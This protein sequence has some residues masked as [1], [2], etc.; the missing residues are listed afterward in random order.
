M[1]FLVIGL[2]SMGKRRIR[3]LQKNLKTIDVFGV[4]TNVERA[5][6]V[7]NEFGITI[8]ESITDAIDTVKFDAAL[9]CT[10]PITHENIILECLKYNLNVFTEINLINSY[11]NRVIQE[12]G[13]KNLKIYLSSTFLKRKEIQFIRQECADQPITYRYHA[14]QYLPDWH[15]WESYKDYFVSNKLTNACRE[16]LAIELPWLISCFGKVEDIKVFKTKISSLE[17]DYDD[18]YQLLMQHCSGVIGSLTVNVVS[19]VAKRDFEVVGEQCQLSWDGTPN[20]LYVFEQD[21]K[22]MTQVKLYDSHEH[23]ESYTKSIVED[24]YLEELKEFV[25]YLTQSDFVP[26]Y[27]FE[28]DYSVI[29][30]I[31]RIESQ[32]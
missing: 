3:L 8:F 31:N 29:E 28:Q 10:S 27:S 17:I 5:N 25:K 21:T 4:D 1:N 7:Q 18:T 30:V 24:A 12:A 11:Y 20:G 6:N 14:G 32:L 26:E 16:I 19:R 13:S 9:V 15:P 23:L 2:G 22:A